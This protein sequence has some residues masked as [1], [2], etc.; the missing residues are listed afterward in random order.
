MFDV[1][2]RKITEIYGLLDC[3][4]LRSGTDST[5]DG[6]PGYQMLPVNR[7]GKESKLG[8]YA[9]RCHRTDE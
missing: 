6:R 3:G 1:A 8:A 2:F 7:P 5:F 9:H 4:Q